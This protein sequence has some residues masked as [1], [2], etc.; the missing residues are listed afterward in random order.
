MALPWSSL[1]KAPILQVVAENSNDITI[2]ITV[3][4]IDKK[5]FFRIEQAVKEEF[6]NNE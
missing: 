1:K 3:Y 6:E 2:E 5:Y 4:P